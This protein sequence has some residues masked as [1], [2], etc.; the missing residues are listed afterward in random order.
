MVK[1]YH[2]HLKDAIFGV[3][4]S[5]IQYLAENFIRPFVIDRKNWLF[6]GN[7]KGAATS[8]GIYTLIETAKANGL[9]AMKYIKYIS[10]NAPKLPPPACLS[11]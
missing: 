4:I 6:A 2:I 7:P 11:N 10:F 8:A 5:N 1:C 9:N 3:A